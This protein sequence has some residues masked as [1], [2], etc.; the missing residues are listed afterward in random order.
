MLLQINLKHQFSAFINKVTFS[1]STSPLFML[2]ETE[3]E[4]YTLLVQKMRIYDVE[5]K[6]ISGWIE[7]RCS[8]QQGVALATMFL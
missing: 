1:M 3:D 6:Q 4:L 7:E 8:R 5:N 2:K